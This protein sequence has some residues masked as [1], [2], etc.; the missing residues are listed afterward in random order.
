MLLTTPDDEEFKFKMHGHIV[1]IHAHK[2]GVGK[3]TISLNLVDLISKRLGS[4][5]TNFT[6][7][8][9][10]DCDPQMNLTNH[11]L[12]D[13]AFEDHLKYLDSSMSEKLSEYKG[14]RMDNIRDYL[15]TNKNAVTYGGFLQNADGIPMKLI[16]GSYEL[17]DLSTQISI[18][19][20]TANKIV[21]DQI[22]QKIRRLKRKPA[23]FQGL[24]RKLIILDLSPS[25][26][27]LNKLLLEAA[28]H[29]II[30]MNC[31]LYSRLGVRLLNRSVDNVII[32]KILGVIFNRVQVYSNKPT[33]P[34]REVMIDSTQALTEICET[35]TNLGYIE[36][37]GGLESLQMRGLTFFD[38]VPN[39][40]PDKLIQIRNNY[41]IICQRI[42]RSLE[43]N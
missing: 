22:L 40:D 2:G 13:V 41:Q 4:C 10:V 38:N 43:I 32:R 33:K 26:N 35:S 30:P 1:A 17:D 19:S 28:D 8:I 20:K 25:L 3:T 39:S 34:E 18:E 31:D 7:I 12:T 16:K 5:Y 36:N 14:I 9:M 23:S 6:E 24:W 29:I 11:L 42:L 21:T 27:G 15:N 37:F